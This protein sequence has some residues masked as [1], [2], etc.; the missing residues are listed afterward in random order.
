MGPTTHHLKSVLNIYGRPFLLSINSRDSKVLI[1]L[2][3]SLALSY[4]LI[5]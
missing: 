5:D 4:V 2:A 3:L 1:E